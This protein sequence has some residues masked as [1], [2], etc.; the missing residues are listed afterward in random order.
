MDLLEKAAF[1]YLAAQGV[2]NNFWPY[3]IAYLK[4]LWNRC[5]FFGQ[6]TFLL[7]KQSLLNEFVNRGLVLA[8]LQGLQGIAE[9]YAGMKQ[10]GES[11]D[12]MVYVGEM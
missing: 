7:E 12:F 1:V 5:V 3:Y 6:A 8:Y 9:Y 2:P 4:R 11:F 10:A